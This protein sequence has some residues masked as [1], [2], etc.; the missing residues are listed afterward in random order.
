MAVDK[1]EVLQKILRLHEFYQ[2]GLIPTLAQHE[3]H[4][5]LDLSS[6]E[7]FLYFTL[8]PCLN[9]QRS[10]PAMWKSAFATWNDEETHYLFFPEQV[11]QTDFLKLQ[12]DLLKHKLAL[13]KNKHTAIWFTLCTTLFEKFDSD[14]RKIFEQT[15]FSVLNT[16]ILLQTNKKDFPY[17]NGLKMSNYWMYILSRYT[18]MHLLDMENISIIPD[19]HVLQASVVL[20]LIP[21]VDVD[22]LKVEKIWYDL[23]LGTGI[24]PVDMHPVLWNWSRNDFVPLV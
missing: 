9:F 21:S 6:R 23:L 13:Q 11:V 10:S 24:N 2:K 4:P 1:T 20:G 14:P 8:P 5:D 16:K 17:L 15:H 3:I 18:N 12:K 19:T 7:N 22:R